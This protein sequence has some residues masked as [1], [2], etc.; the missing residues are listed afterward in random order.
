MKFLIGQYRIAWSF[1]TQKLKWIFLI[2]TVAFVLLTIL[3]YYICPSETACD[4]FSMAMGEMLGFKTN[5]D[6]I[7]LPGDIA[8]M[9]K[10]ETALFIFGNNVSASASL[11]LYGLIPFIFLP[12][13]GIVVNAFAIGAMLIVCDIMLPAVSASKLIVYGL[14]PHGIIEIP[15]VLLAI[16]MGI[17]MCIFLCR[18]IFGKDKDKSFKDLIS[19]LVR[20]YLCVILPALAVSA[21]IEA[22][23][24]PELLG[25]L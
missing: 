20:V 15:T 8:S 2:S 22:F 6:K 17:Y 7:I 4:F 21:V 5:A 10:A 18:R 19:Q 25:V 1:I 3:F 16:S 12:V 23:V 14:L 11:I 9:S 24:T 13:L